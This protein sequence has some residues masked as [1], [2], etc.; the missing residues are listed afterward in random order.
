[1]LRIEKWQDVDLHCISGM[2]DT[3]H[4]GPA[5]LTLEVC[6]RNVRLKLTKGTQL[7]PPCSQCFGHVPHK[8]SCSNMLVIWAGT[9]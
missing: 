4:N 2:P 1:M 8:Q 5:G 9:S 6:T 7:K 3:P